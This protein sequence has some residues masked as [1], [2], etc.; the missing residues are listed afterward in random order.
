[1]GCKRT[2][3]DVGY[4]LFAVERVYDQ[5][6]VYDCGGPKKDSGRIINDAIHRAFP[7]PEQIDALFIS[8][9]DI[10]HISGIFYL[11]SHCNVK[12]IFLPALTD[13]DKIFLICENDDDSFINFVKNPINSIRGKGYGN[14]QIIFVQDGEDSRYSD[15]ENEY[16]LNEVKEISDIPS[17]ANVYID[18]QR[19]WVFVPWNIRKFSSDEEEHFI[20]DIKSLFKFC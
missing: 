4:A 16:F 6:V 18:N 7:K 14:V 2:F 12:N 15:E 11:L 3:Y 20:K 5:T 1:M 8:H 17:G 13:S 9:Y 10:D 19:K